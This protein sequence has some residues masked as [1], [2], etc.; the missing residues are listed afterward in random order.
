MNAELGTRPAANRT[1][2]SADDAAQVANYRTPSVLAVVSLLLGLAA[3]LCVLGPLLLVV[4]LVGAALSVAALRRIAASDGALVGARAAIVGLVL[5]IVCGIAVVTHASLTRQLQSGQ[6]AEF[7][8]EWITL[9]LAGDIERAFG[10]TTFGPRFSS[11]PPDEP[12]PPGGDPFEQFVDLPVMRALSAVGEEAD[13]LAGPAVRYAAQGDGEFMVQQ[14][15]LVTP[16]TADAEEDGPRPQP[17]AVLLTLHRT[18]LPGESQT[19]WFVASA[20]S[21]D[22]Q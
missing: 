15:Y 17:I 5:S 16:H 22:A 2:F 6:A 1:E 14:E 7:G 10:L 13:V 11:P 19:T 9:V 18:R 20:D 8:R 21:G 12:P 4:P 3:P